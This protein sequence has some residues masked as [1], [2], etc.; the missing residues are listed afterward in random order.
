LLSIFTYPRPSEQ[1][2][3]SP[4]PIY[5]VCE[6]ENS[7]AG[8][9]AGIWTSYSRLEGASQSQSLPIVSRIGGRAGLSSAV[10]H[11]LAINKVQLQPCRKALGQTDFTI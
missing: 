2:P 10:E 1:V 8:R 7:R 4:H 6:S 3:A 5:S 9:E 11:L